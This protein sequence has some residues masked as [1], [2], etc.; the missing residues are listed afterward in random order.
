MLEPHG[1]GALVALPHGAGRH[2]DQGTRT[3]PPPR[4]GGGGRLGGS[5][6]LAGRPAW[7]GRG[8]AGTCCRDAHTADD[9]TAE[10]FARVLQA[11][12]GGSGPDHSLRAY[13]LT[14]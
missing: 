12:R 2:R 6:A 5:G 7:G 9:L 13:L 14:T 11:V 4:R 8:Y 10:F 3:R 1:R